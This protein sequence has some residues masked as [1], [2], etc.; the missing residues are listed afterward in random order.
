MKV[1]IGDLVTLK[2]LKIVKM[3]HVGVVIEVRKAYCHVF[4]SDCQRKFWYKNKKTV[5]F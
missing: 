3:N 5:K 1:K 4:W 2:D